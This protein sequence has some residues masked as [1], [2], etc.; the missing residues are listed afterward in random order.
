[1]LLIDAG[2]SVVKSRHINGN[3]IIDSRFVLATHQAQGMDDFEAY[4]KQLTIDQIYIASVASAAVTS[5]ITRVIEKCLPNAALKRLLTLPS[6][7]RI[8]NAYLDHTQLGVD[9]WLT[10]LAADK[11]KDQDV[12][13]VDAG[14]AITIDLVSRK[15]NHLGGAIIAGVHTDAERFK[16]IFPAVDFNHPD[17]LQNSD[18]GRSTAQCIHL[19]RGDNV[20]DYTS[21]LVRR[22]HDLLQSPVQVILTG[23]DAEKI[24]EG[25]SLP[26]QITPDLVFQ[27]MLKQIQLQG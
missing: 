6:L 15:S 8:H 5:Q 22:W 19:T 17:I 10:I 4:L 9:R 16:Q 13:I 24:G 18:P 26:Y 25:L 12:I 14:S 1:M 11:F 20:I 3:Q 7:G 21:E 2:N 27:G 23:Y